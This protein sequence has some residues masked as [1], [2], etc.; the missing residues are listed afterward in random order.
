MKKK[1]SDC[2]YC[3]GIVQEQI[4]SRELRWKGNLFIIENIPAGVCKQCGEKFLE[5]QV[6]KNIDRVLQNKTKP[7]KK[8]AVP[9]YLL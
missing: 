4:I 3:G 7:A 5:P 9:V 6:A 2:F 8:I 1:Y